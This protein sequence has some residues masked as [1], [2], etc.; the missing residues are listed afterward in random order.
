MKTSRSKLLAAAAMLLATAIAQ[1]QEKGG[2][3]MFLEVGVD[4]PQALTLYAGLGFTKVGT[5]K[6]YYSAASGGADALVL[7]LSLPANFA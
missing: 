5:R 1:A 2:K 4:N 6:A 3:T 7:R